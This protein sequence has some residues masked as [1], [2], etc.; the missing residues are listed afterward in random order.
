[1]NEKNAP[2]F[3]INIRGIRESVE[4]MNESGAVVFGLLCGCTRDVRIIKHDEYLN[5]NAQ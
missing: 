2:A 5:T 4:K 3:S 1:M